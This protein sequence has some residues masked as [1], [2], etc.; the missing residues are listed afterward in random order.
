M[1]DWDDDD[2]NLERAARLWGQAGSAERDS[3]LRSSNSFLN[4]L[5]R[6]GE[7]ALVQWIVDLLRQIPWHTVK[8]W[9]LAL[10]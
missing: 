9:I 3:A 4:F 7:S 1:A 6:I 8:D 2:A 5:R 10:F